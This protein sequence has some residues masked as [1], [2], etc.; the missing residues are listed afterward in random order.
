MW[1]SILAAS[2]RALCYVGWHL[3]EYVYSG[4]GSESQRKCKRCGITHVKQTK[5]EE[6]DKQWENCYT[7]LCSIYGSKDYL[8]EFLRKIEV[9]P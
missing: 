7:D 5:W 4:D 9:C 1:Q 2:I 6:V 8:G 3:W